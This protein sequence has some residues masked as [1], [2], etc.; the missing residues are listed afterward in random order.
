M[1]K[2]E[3]NEV[4]F[5]VLIV[6]TDINAYYMARCYHEAYGRKAKLIG[7]Q[8]MAFTSYSK[9]IDLTIEPNLWNPEVF[10][11]TLEDFALQHQGKKLNLIGTND[12]YVRLIVENRDFLSK[13]YYFHLLDFYG[14]IDFLV[15]VIS[16]L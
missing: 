11:K 16:R 6:G 13:Y 2:I 14:L 4:D 15:D 12:T 1:E 10:K 8:E 7:K 3:V 5:E 9:I